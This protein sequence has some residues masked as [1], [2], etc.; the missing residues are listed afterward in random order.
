[1]KLNTAR[2]L[3]ATFIGLLLVHKAQAHPVSGHEQI[4]AFAAIYAQLNSTG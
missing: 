3:F 4:T 1:M 2:T